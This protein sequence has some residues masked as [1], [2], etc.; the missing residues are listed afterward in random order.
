MIDNELSGTCVG[1]P[2][3][4]EHRTYGADRMPVLARGADTEGQLL[5]YYI[6][7]KGKWQWRPEV[8]PDFDDRVR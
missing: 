4:G 3:D 5:G 8:A 2:H 1:G 6:H 7:R